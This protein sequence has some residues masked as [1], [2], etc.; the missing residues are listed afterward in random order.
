MRSLLCGQEPNGLASEKSRARLPQCQPSALRSCEAEAT[1]LRRIHE[2][3]SCR[4]SGVRKCADLEDSSLAGA[5]EAALSRHRQRQTH[6]AQ[7][8]CSL[9]SS[10]FVP[11][12]GQG[13][14][15]LLHAKP[16]ARDGFGS[17]RSRQIFIV[18]LAPNA[19]LKMQASSGMTG[20]G[21]TDTTSSIS[22]ASA[23]C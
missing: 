20:L 19:Q 16:K 2:V 14:A 5:G 9:H 22:V 3:W 15:L 6:S 8:F 12:G 11:A 7:K 1:V 23:E 13:S 18:R 17:P 4:T 10:T 21:L